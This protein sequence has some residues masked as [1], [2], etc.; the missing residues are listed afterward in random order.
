MGY[1]IEDD[2]VGCDYCRDCGRK[3]IEVRFCDKCGDYS[4]EWNPLYLSED[5]EELCLDCLKGRYLSKICDDMDETRCAHCGTDAEEMF[6]VD[7]EWIC[8]E[9]LINLTERAVD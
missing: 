5:G 8:E 9:C 7:G 1:R 2:C 4:D 3:H 6:L